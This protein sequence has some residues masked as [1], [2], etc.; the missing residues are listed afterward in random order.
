MESGIEKCAMLILTSGKRDIV[1][2]I[3]Q[4]NQ[5]RVKSL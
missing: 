1:E 2:G 3:E 4:A 5:E